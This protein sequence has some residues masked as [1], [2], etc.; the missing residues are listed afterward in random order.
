MEKSIYLKNWRSYLN[1]ILI[2]LISQ[3]VT[4]AQSLGPV[5]GS[6]A[7]INGLSESKGRGKISKMIEAFGGSFEEFDYEV[8]PFRRSVKRLETSHVDFQ[9]P[10]TKEDVRG[11]GFF[12]SRFYI[13]KV[14]FRLYFHK[15]KILSKEDITGK[16]QKIIPTVEKAHE[17][18]FPFKVDTSTCMECLLKKINDK[19]AIAAIDASVAADFVIKKNGLHNIRS[20]PFEEYESRFSFKDNER[21][22]LV[23][24]KFFEVFQKLKKEG[25]IPNINKV[26]E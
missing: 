22:R 15:D 9:Y 16:N 11:T 21:G 1:L 17:R 2:L 14:R 3:Q 4:M 20:I 12:T 5:F 10:I 19:R 6:V 25:R 13:S 18:N 24:A 7:K 23:E 8:V 26:E